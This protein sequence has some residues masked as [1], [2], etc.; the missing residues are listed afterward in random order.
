[1][2]SKVNSCTL[3]GIDGYLVDVEVDVSAG[4]PSFSIVGLP[5]TSVQEARER[6]RS[7]IKNSGFEF[8][9]RR[10]TVNLAPADIR[11]E[12]PAFDLPI[13]LGI[14]MATEQLQAET[15]NIE[16]VVFTGEMSLNGDLRKASGVLP[17]AL[18]CKNQNKT[19]LIVPKPN[20][21]EAS[22]VKELRVYAA[23]CLSE[24]V[25]FLNGNI[26]IS[27]F[28]NHL[29]GDVFKTGC[30]AE[31]FS[32]VK[33]Q[34]HAKRAL[35][36]AA[37]GGHNVL[38]VGPPG[39][40]KTMLA[41]RLPGILPPFTWD[42]AIEA[43]KIFSCAGLLNGTPLLL[44]RPFRSPH[45]SI[46]N[47]GLVGGGTY[48]RPGEISL[49]HYGVLFL[50]EFTEFHRDVLEVMRQPLEEGKVTISR[51]SA[52]LTYPAAF[53]L[54][55]AMNPCPC[56]F[57][58]DPVK[59]CTCT[60]FQIQR[61]LKKISGPLLD[62]IDIHVEVPRLE[63]QK[64]DSR[65]SGES[66]SVIRSRVTGARDI[67]LERFK[68]DAFYTNTR[69]QTR[70]IKKYC[71]LSEDSRKLLKDCMENL[72]LSARAYDKIIKVSRTIADL[73]GSDKIELHHVAEAAQ[74]RS[75][76]R[77]LWS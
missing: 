20:A 68:K 30:V 37:A 34:E 44:S 55:A 32:D 48:P 19:A 2:L 35:E 74:Y 11:K 28:V 39:S 14:L 23:G 22:L 18:Q 67:Q 3:S 76:D 65:E 31:D 60:P 5:D 25:E 33:G 69:M 36:V 13:A 43:T 7:A 8:P 64:L 66:S 41:R 12:G 42:E 49:S 50:D 17:M 4:L 58:S 54:V 27:S 15:M 47:A 21:P 9:A 72:G 63:I 51:A 56:G 38:L 52:T 10:I 29:N 6:V 53:M 16:D 46:S 24:V 75:L 40:G 59:T 26:K 61:Y 57:F 73:E 70:H 71:A 45:H 77:K 1:M 62:R